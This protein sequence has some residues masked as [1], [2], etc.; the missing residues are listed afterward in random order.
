[1]TALRQKE[2]KALAQLLNEWRLTK[3]TI[4]TYQL[5]RR[6]FKTE[7]YG[8]FFILNKCLWDWNLLQNAL[9]INFKKVKRSETK[10]IVTNHFLD[11]YTQ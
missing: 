7:K 8:R 6:D 2:W 5:K 11:K 9:K 10:I 1:M 4:N 3:F